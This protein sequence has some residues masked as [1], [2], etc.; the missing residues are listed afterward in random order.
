MSGSQQI[1]CVIF[2]IGGVVVGSPLAA[3]NEYEEEHGL[4]R[5]WINLAITQQGSQGAF[6]RFERN[7]TDLYSFYK[8]FGE[9]LSNTAQNNEWYRKFCTV[10]GMPIP[11]NLP[12]S[13]EIDGRRL[14]G[15]MMRSSYN[16]DP[17]MLRAISILRESGRFKVAALTNNFKP[18]SA[19]APEGEAVPTLDEEVKHLGIGPAFAQLKAFFHM[20][21]ESSEVGMRKPDPEF[22]KYALR[23][24]QVEAQETV[25]LDDI[26]INLKSAKKLGINTIRV[27]PTSSVPALQELEKM[28]GM[29]L[30]DEED[31]LEYEQK[32]AKRRKQSKL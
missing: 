7:E 12:E 10:R 17:K 6:Q 28:V 2:D 13:I 26:G 23:E 9:E 15:F 25:F 4:P 21:I 29:Q 14:F 19:P 24:L 5:H 16:P 8:K 22:Y 30:L 11:K 31:V 3:I 20:F 18:P 32:L 27:H 1:K